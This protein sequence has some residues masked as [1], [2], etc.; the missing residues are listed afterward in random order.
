MSLGR[1]SGF[2]LWVSIGAAALNASAKSAFA[3][4][5]SF[6][7]FKLF[8]ERIPSA[9]I[10]D[11]PLQSHGRLKPLDSFAREAILYVTG[12]YS[13]SG[14]DAVQIYLGLMVSDQ[15]A[16]LDLIN[17]RDPELRVA[18][19]FS[20][21]DRHLSLQALE[22]SKLQELA[23]PGMQKQERNDRNLTPREKSAMEAIQQVWLMRGILSGRHLLEAL[24]LPAAA[25][26]PSA[27]KP[28]PAVYAKTQ[29]FLKALAN[30]E[31]DKAAPLGR[32]LV[33]IAKTQPMPPLFE[34]SVDKLGAEVWFNKAHLFRWA[35]ILYLVLGLVLVTP[36]AKGFRKS[37]K[38]LLFAAVPFLLHIAGFGMR[39]YITSVAPVTN[40]YGTM[41]W[42]AFG[43]VLF[44]SFLFL[45]YRNAFIYGV[46]LLGASLTLFLT[47][48]LPLVLSPDL[49]PIVAVLRSNFWLTIHVLTITIS[50]A[51]FTIG[52]LLG[53]FALVRA[54]V[55]GLKTRKRG[56][57]EASAK[58][59][60]FYTEYAMITYRATQ[61]GVFFLTA[62]IILGGIWADYSWGR[63]WGWD[64]KE[65]WS[66]IADLGYLAILHARYLGWLG[67]F[68]LLASSPVAYLL[69]VMAWYGVN[70]I[71]A[72]GLH[73]YGF[74]SGGAFA[75][76]AFVAV[77]LV[78][79]A[80]ALAVHNWNKSKAKS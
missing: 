60:K 28:D 6:E 71:L 2:L 16:Q 70:F 10:A 17:I 80:V 76:T 78:L 77:Q 27:N 21:K 58:D 37:P 54:I 25:G 31:Q 48:S 46:I 20:K 1:I 11:L 55:R 62:G 42:V 38:I 66:L 18:L 39:V 22:A 7:A 63:F 32:E 79:L 29:E 59:D 56:A 47:E 15:A 69:V 24:T 49:D 41:I 30:G 33:R 19:G 36:L 4:E 35:A 75:V 52:M 44:G 12:K 64:P 8:A 23:A 51:A 14:L 34:Q 13:K 67:P 26:A 61:I 45:S 72:S 53:N 57:V 3:S 68:G 74:S 50:Y 65:T 43:V 40:M 73:S 9:S 5:Q